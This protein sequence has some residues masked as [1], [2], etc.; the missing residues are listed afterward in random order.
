VTV[1]VPGTSADQPEQA[2]RSVLSATLRAQRLSLVQLRAP[3]LRAA[4]YHAR[5]RWMVDRSD[6]VIGFPH[7]DNPLSSTWYAIR[8]AAEQ[9]RPR[10]IIPI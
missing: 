6:L 1:V 8:Y 2:R 5:N 10:L 9:V 3:E 7:G 4:A